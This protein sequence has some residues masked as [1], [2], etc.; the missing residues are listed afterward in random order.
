MENLQ[1]RGRSVMRT[2][3]GVAIAIWLSQPAQA[4]T[5]IYEFIDVGSTAAERGR[6]ICGSRIA[7]LSP[8][9]A[10]RLSCS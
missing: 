8:E 9:R 2:V 5:P 4:E 10:E 3:I 7:P 1:D 6:A